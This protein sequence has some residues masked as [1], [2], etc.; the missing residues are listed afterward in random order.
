MSSE[1]GG[2]EG[3]VRV[4]LRRLALERADLYALLYRAWPAITG[5]F[6]LL[7]IAAA[8]TPELQGYYFTITAILT[9]QTLL[10]LGL[11]RALQQITSHEWA[12][13]TYVD[14]DEVELTGDEA[15]LSRLATLVRFARVWYAWAAAF[16]VLGLGIGGYAFL[17]ATSESGLVSW[18]TTW[19]FLA[20]AAGL[21]LLLSPAL[22]ILEGCNQVTEVYRFRMIQGIATRVALWSGMLLGGGLWALLLERVLMLLTTAVFLVVRYR[23]LFARLLAHPRLQ[24]GYWAHEIWPL[25]WRFA[26]VWLAG[27]LPTLFVPALFAFEGPVVAGQIGMTWALVSALLAVAFAVILTKMPRFAMHAARKEYEALDELFARS[28][29]GSLLLMVSGTL[30][31]VGILA[32]LEQSELPLA[33][34]FLSPLTTLVFLLAILAQLLKHAMA[35]YLRAHKREPYLALSLIEAAITLAV[36]YPLGKAY[37]AEG[38]A[39]GFLVIA[40]ATLTPAYLI[41]RRCRVRWHAE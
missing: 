23:R 8:F 24:P 16:A 18:E 37:G 13:L 12:R 7:I 1:S 2:G 28:L 33:E 31:A 9:L 40:T 30:V 19:I 36:L 35:T 14:G 17:A 27:F 41:F 3:G 25:Q 5:P 22:L 6:T 4:W 32:L 34:R 20:V 26:T 39:W 29:R 15:A 21:N 11:G 10:E 38:L